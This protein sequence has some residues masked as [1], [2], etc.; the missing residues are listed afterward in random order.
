MS[1][2]VWGKDQKPV[3]RFG[4]RTNSED[5][6]SDSAFSRSA[7]VSH[8]ERKEILRKAVLG[9]VSSGWKL[10]F[11]SEF[12]SVLEIGKRPNHVLH[13]LLSIFTLGFWIFVWIF[14]SL[15]SRPRRITISVDAYGNIQYN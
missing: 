11:E 10:V 9:Y 6:I 15:F 13:L 14:L 12:E 7:L 4:R 8:S 2:F 3:V 5:G 1:R